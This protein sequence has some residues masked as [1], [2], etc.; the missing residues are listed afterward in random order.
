MEIERQFPDKKRVPV[1]QRVVGIGRDI[2][3]ARSLSCVPKAI[4]ILN[5]AISCFSLD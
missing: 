2:I 1:S 5:A 4:S 3:A